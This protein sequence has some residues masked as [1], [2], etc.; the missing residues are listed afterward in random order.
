[1]TDLDDVPTYHGVGFFGENIFDLSHRSDLDREELAALYPE[2][3]GDLD[4]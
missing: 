3:A 4:V 1:M 2:I